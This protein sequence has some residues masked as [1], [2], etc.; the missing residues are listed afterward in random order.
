MKEFYQIAI[1]SL[2]SACIGACIVLFM[3]T[4]KIKEANATI[5]F[6][7]KLIGDER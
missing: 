4:D 2:L 7:E 3:V 6:Y 1:A 5:E